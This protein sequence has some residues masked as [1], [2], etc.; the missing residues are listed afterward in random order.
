VS[1]TSHISLLTSIE[2]DS[3]RFCSSIIRPPPSLAWDHA[4]FR[5][6]SRAWH[7]NNQ[8]LHYACAYGATEQ[9]LHV[10]TDGNIGTITAVDNRGRT[11]LH[12]AL[13]NADRPASPG[14]VSILL[15]QDRSVVN[16][17][18]LEGNLPIHLLRT[19]ALAIKAEEK[20]KIDNCQRCFS[21]YL[22]ARPRAEGHLLM[23]LQGLPDW[24]RDY[25]VVSPVV[26]RILNVKIATRFPTAVILM[27]FFF[28]VIVVIFFPLAV[29]KSI[30]DRGDDDNIPEGEGGGNGK[31]YA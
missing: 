15:S 27:D 6:D 3:S 24:L 13:G 1:I 10:L 21:L 17:I 12:F 5:T 16:I 29:V 22:D 20:D 7:V 11:P 14:V 26:Q 8:P 9:A 2:S 28:Y 30:T 18:D 23:G 19:C 4:S 31:R 25:A